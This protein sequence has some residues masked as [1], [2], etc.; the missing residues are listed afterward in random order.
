MKRDRNAGN[1]HRSLQIWVYNLVNR[2]VLDKR[3]GTQV[4]KSR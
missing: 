3:I 1:L 2:S 4:F